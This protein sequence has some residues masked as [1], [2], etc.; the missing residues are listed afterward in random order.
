MWYSYTIHGT[1]E[2][3]RT[4][5]KKKNNQINAGAA[6]RVWRLLVRNVQNYFYMLA[7]RNRRMLNKL[8]ETNIERQTDRHSW[9][10]GVLIKLNEKA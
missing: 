2:Q 4:E 5:P 3:N 8:G 9:L 7:G 10:V 6:V 1:A